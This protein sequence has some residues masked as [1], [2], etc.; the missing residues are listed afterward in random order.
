M[1]EIGVGVVGTAFMGKAHSLA[2]AAAGTA[3]GNGLRPRLEMVCDADPEI[4]KQKQTEMGFAR[5][6]SDY[7]DLVNDPKIDLI[8]VCVPNSLHAEISIAASGPLSN[9]SLATFI[10]DAMSILNEAAFAAIFVN[11]STPFPKPNLFNFSKL[12]VTNFDT[13]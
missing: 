4:A 11:P 2:Y 5:S 13:T 10:V 8:S 1:K 7:M 12:S 3:F 9:I 6:T